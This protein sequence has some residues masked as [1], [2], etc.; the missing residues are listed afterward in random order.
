MG[1]QFKTSTAQKFS[2]WSALFTQS[3]EGIR[4]SYFLVT[5]H[6]KNS[7]SM[8]SD[9]AKRMKWRE[10]KWNLLCCRRPGFSRVT[11]DLIYANQFTLC[12]QIKCLSNLNN[13]HIMAKQ[14]RYRSN[15]M[16]LWVKNINNSDII[17]IFN[18]LQDYYTVIKEYC[19]TQTTNSDCKTV[20]PKLFSHSPPLTNCQ[21]FFTADILTCD[22][23]HLCTWMQTPLYWH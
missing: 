3:S 7:V 1:S 19:V 8:G 10:A 22:W 4:N 16:C 12:W 15:T 11:E 13:Q 5:S 20:H 23:D 2:Y 14:S 21:D 6:W 9:W 17:I 18:T